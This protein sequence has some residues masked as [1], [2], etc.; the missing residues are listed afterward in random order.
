MDTDSY[1]LSDDA[2]K[3]L[4]DLGYIHPTA[5]GKFKDELKSW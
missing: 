1:F 2:Y 3:I 4:D 5:I